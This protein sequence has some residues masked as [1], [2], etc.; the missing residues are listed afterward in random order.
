MQASLTTCSLYVSVDSY[1]ALRS[2]T[3]ENL[4]QYPY[5]VYFRIRYSFN[6]WLTITDKTSIGP[7]ALADTFSTKL[8]ID[9]AEIC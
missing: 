5:P 3:S 1:I 2:H 6:L 8:L 7:R 9:G 4:Q